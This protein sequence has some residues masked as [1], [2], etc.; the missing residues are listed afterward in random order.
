MPPSN[1]Q[2]RRRRDEERG[3]GW[4]EIVAIDICSTPCA[5][6]CSLP[7]QNG[8]RGPKP[9]VQTGSFH[10]SPSPSSCSRAGNSLLLC[11]CSW[12]V[13]AGCST[14]TAAAAALGARRLWSS[15]RANTSAPRSSQRDPV[16]GLFSGTRHQ[17]DG[18]HS[19]GRSLLW[20][21]VNCLGRSHAMPS[22]PDT[23]ARF[24]AAYSGGI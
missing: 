4:V 20:P 10:L 5:A 18:R 11:R 2:G 23:T 1:R 9:Q 8:F 14:H 21:C 22:Q 7:V 17:H 3:A 19:D 24:Q 15:G 13:P 6:P 12:G 16:H